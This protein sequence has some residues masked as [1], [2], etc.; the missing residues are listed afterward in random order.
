MMTAMEMMGRV[1]LGNRWAFLMEA[2][3][4]ERHEG[5]LDSLLMAYREEHRHYHTLD[6]IE[7]GLDVLDR[8][9]A[10]PMVKLAWWFHDARY[11]V[12]RHDNE[13]MSALWL[14]DSMSSEG[15]IQERGMSVLR[16]AARL[17]NLTARHNVERF[18]VRG[19]HMVVAD[20]FR[21]GGNAD[22]YAAN[23]F[24][25]RKE[26]G[27]FSDEDWCAG[28]L[29]FVESMLRE[30]EFVF[31]LAREYRVL[32]DQAQVNLDAEYKM[33]LRVKNGG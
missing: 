13:A 17:V 30:R 3:H 29:N 9:D 20:L 6:H 33:L 8:L 2:L 25:I 32:E 27:V 5:V 15:L 24:D 7:E 22:T 4:F 16:E 19:C 21:M 23:T 28:R 10:D 18:D 1:E 14:V 26:Y 31:P 11:N 12:S